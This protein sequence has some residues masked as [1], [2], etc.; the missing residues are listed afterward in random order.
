MRT[1]L[2]SRD[3]VMVSSWAAANFEYHFTEAS[4]LVS[5]LT[6]LRLEPHTPGALSNTPEQ[7][8]PQCLHLPSVKCQSV[9]SYALRPMSSARQLWQ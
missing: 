7:G 3:R 1:P 4:L 6:G 5:I 2:S 9:I 8:V